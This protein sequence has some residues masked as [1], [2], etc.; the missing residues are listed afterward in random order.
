MND[1]LLEENINVVIVKK[2]RR[3]SFGK[4]VFPFCLYVN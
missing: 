4:G 1:G 3:I 2:E